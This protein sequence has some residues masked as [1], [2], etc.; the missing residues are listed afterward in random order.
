VIKVKVQN[1]TGVLANL[2]QP[3]THTQVT[4]AEVVLKAITVGGIPQGHPW[5]VSLRRGAISALVQSAV[6][7]RASTGE[8]GTTVLYDRM[9]T[10]EKAAAS[11]RLGM[12]F[13]AVVADRVL[14]TEIL[15]HVRPHAGG[16]GRRA[17]LIGYDRGGALHV[18]EAKGRAYDIT[19]ALRDGKKQAEETMV[20]DGS[21]TE[22]PVASRSVS[23]A[24]L[25]QAETIQVVLADPPESVPR[26][27]L[28][29]DSNGFIVE[30]YRPILELVTA[31][32]VEEP[33]QPAVAARAIGAWLPGGD[34][35]L[36]L[37]RLNYDRL[38]RGAPPTRD[39]GSIDRE[40]WQGL[41]EV[42]GLAVGADGHV[43]LLRRRR[44]PFD[45]PPYVDLDEPFGDT[46]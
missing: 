28:M 23:A 29:A 32:G 30:H 17:D 2:N 13:A 5:H 27:R 15:H 4:V 33:D 12:A 3:L 18:V 25:A 35:W 22:L 36:G 16:V 10:T 24:L 37:D 11:F 42:P 9:E 26:V 46:R 34:A 44:G 40:R 20:V 38:R 1:Y 21:D 19:K 7:V 6:D 41:Q 31:T 43:L 14:K 8:L 45:P 39:F